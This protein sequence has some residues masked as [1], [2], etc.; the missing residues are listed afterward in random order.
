MPRNI[1]KPTNLSG[2]SNGTADTKDELVAAET[3][4]ERLYL[5]VENP[6][7]GT[8]IITVSEGA[9]GEELT[10]FTLATGESVE[11]KPEPNSNLS[12]V[13]QGRLTIESSATFQ[14]FIARV[15]VG[16]KLG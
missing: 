13:P 9:D 4:G 6:S 8:D 15:G 3:T 12:F 5:Y 10:L 14:P 7:G 16:S 11:Y 1:I 2:S